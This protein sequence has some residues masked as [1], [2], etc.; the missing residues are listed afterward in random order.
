MIVAANKADTPSERHL[1]HELLELGF[2][3]PSL[4][5]AGI[6][7]EFLDSEA[8]INRQIEIRVDADSL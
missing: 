4:I 3:E 5:S 2:D 6:L 8:G 7:N 1:A